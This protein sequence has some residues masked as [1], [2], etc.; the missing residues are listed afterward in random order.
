MYFLY[1]IPIY[2]HP[3]SGIPVW[4]RILYNFVS[5]LAYHC[6]LFCKS[7]KSGIFLAITVECLVQYGF[8]GAYEN[9]N[10]INYA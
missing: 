9:Q 3:S 7:L 6:I 4:D 2:P 5:F 1:I 10:C 8:A